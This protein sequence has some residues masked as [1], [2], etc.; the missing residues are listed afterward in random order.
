M[1]VPKLF[2]G[3]VAVA[4]LSGCVAQTP[5]TLA[6]PPE[7]SSSPSASASAA[8]AAPISWLIDFNAVGPLTIQGSFSAEAGKVAPYSRE[9]PTAC[10]SPVAS[11]FSHD[12][13]PTV[14][15]RVAGTGS[16]VISTI[17]VSRDAA[18]LS[19]SGILVATA[20]GIGIGSSESNVIA[21]YPEAIRSAQPDFNAYWLSNGEARHLVFR[22]RGGIVDGISLQADQQYYWDYCGTSNG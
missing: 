7:S 3:L 11:A 20:K 5:G 10:P 9:S 8:S 12:G 15:V 16:N 17:F 19:G 21:A 2:F 4:L 18:V 1:R 13:S 22:V 6:K 14:L